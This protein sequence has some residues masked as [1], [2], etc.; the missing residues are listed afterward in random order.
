MT[1]MA[2]RIKG[3]L[4]IEGQTDAKQIWI[5]T[6]STL[7]VLL[8]P[9]FAEASTVAST[10]GGLFCNVKLTANGYVR[11][12]GAVSFVSGAF[13][14]VRGVLLLKKHGENPNDSQVVKAIA[15]LFGGGLLL[16]LPTVV[17]IMQM[18]IFG[19][20]PKSGTFTCSGTPGASGAASLDVMMQN[21]V[22]DV[23]GP[24]FVL[25]SVLSMI[26][27]ITMIF[28]ALLRGAKTG[29]D[30]RASNPKDI[31]THLVL[32]AVLVSIGTVLPDVLKT[33]FGVGTVSQMS[34]FPA[35]GWSK[36]VGAADTK[37]ADNTIKAI[38]AFVQ[39]IGGI[40]FLRGWLIIK[41][42]I[43]GGGQ[44]TVPQ[45]ATHIIGGAMAIN[46]DKMLT[47]LDKTFG[48]GVFS[49]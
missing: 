30:P 20:A 35:I 22:K 3:W 14:I 48:T 19:G 25:L 15:H 8:W 4:S 40:S 5:F 44:A 39:I 28:K 1:A 10:L 11:I 43:E 21:F 6:L 32:G 13:I 45:G 46:I 34:S 33:I 41:T 49:S 18:T 9:D 16:S 24:I 27:G 37:A 12:I 17:A 47:I 29:A 42:A 23:H 36:L 7:L 38:M 26:I 2:S 31:V